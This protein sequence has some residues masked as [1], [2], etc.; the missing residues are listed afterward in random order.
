[1]LS[2]GLPEKSI[3]LLGDIPTI[4]GPLVRSCDNL[5]RGS[6]DC[7]S[8]NLYLFQEAEIKEKRNEHQC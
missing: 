7:F 8:P 4:A 2:H 3:E 1:V 6:I 5:S